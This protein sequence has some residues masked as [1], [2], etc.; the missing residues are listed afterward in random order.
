MWV[1]LFR[2]SK[3]RFLNIFQEYIIQVGLHNEEKPVFMFRVF[4]T[5]L[6]PTGNLYTYCN[7]SYHCGVFNENRSRGHRIEESPYFETRNYRN[8]VIR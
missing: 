3:R 2:F 1:N 5:Y 7:G 8:S 4:A 6:R